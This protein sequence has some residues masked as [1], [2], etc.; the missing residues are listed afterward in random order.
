VVGSSLLLLQLAPGAFAP[1]LAL[2][3]LPRVVA[4]RII[5]LSRNRLS[6]PV[7]DFAADGVKL[8]A[9]LP[10]L[11]EG[12]CYE[13]KKYFRRK[14]CKK[15]TILRRRLFFQSQSKWILLFG[16][17]MGTFSVTCSRCRWPLEPEST[18]PI[19]INGGGGVGGTLADSFLL[20][21]ERKK[22]IA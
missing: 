11:G 13:F 6:R 9:L 7:A 21:L 19:D 15:L 2:P 22:S 5:R 12:Q 4:L 10:V 14:K 3:P 16:D 18:L 8:L 17:K 20:E 1:L